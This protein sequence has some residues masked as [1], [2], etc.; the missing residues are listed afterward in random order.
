MNA[1]F[2]PSSITGL[3]A[4][5]AVGDAVSD[6]GAGDDAGVDADVAPVLAV[7]SEAR[8]PSAQADVSRARAMADR[9]SGRVLILVPPPGPPEVSHAP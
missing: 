8:P 6:A 2:L 3:A 4:A 7:V 9:A 1:K 5:V